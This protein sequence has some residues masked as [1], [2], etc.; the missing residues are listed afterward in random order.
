V[1][2]LIISLFYF[3]GGFKILFSS[4]Q[5]FRIYLSIGFI[6]HGVQ[7]LL[8]EFIVQTGIVEL[9]FNIPR[10]LGSAC[11]MLSPLIYLRGKVK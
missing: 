11:L 7:F 10:V 6:L 5:K 8:N 1:I 4:N 9:F 3:I 2:N